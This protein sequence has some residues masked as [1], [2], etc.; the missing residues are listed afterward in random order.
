[1]KQVADTVGG[2][3]WYTTQVKTGLGRVLT[4]AECKIVMKCYTSSKPFDQTVEDL[5]NASN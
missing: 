4:D 3:M 2:W 5:K 1:M